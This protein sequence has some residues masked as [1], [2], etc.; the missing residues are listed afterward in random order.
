MS[1]KKLTAL[2]VASLVAVAL[3]APVFAEGET[4]SSLDAI[5]K[6]QEVMKTIGGTMRSAGT[7]TGDARVEAAQTIVDN[8]AL[9]GELFP[10]DSQ[11]GGNTEALPVIWT[12]PE[13]FMTA[14]NAAVTA[15]AAVLAA[16]QSGDDATWGASLKALGATCGGCHTTYRAM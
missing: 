9:L 11:T 8:F 2:T 16:A 10:E 3:A 6:R 4:F 14:Y 5:V 13:G 1:L 7:A 12:D 15:S